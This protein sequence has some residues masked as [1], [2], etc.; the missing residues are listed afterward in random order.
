MS[1][2]RCSS[3]ARLAALLAALLL[4]GC[5]TLREPPPLELLALTAER[6][7]ARNSPVA[8]LLWSAEARGGVAPLS[9][10]FISAERNGEVRKQRGASSVWAWQP[11]RSG[12]YR[13]KVIVRDQAGNRAE[14]PWSEEIEI[15]RPLFVVLPLQNLSGRPA[16]LTEI[17]TALLAHLSAAGCDAVADQEMLA[18]MAGQRMRNVGGITGSLAGKLTEATGAEAVL[19]TSLELFEEQYPPRIALI[20][21]LVSLA[22]APEVLWMDSVGLA[23]DDSPGFLG[24]GIIEQPEALRDKALGMLMR[25]LAEVLAGMEKTRRV[26]GKFQPKTAYGTQDMGREGKARIAVTP[27]FNFSDRKYGG[28]I[29]A[30]HFLAALQQSGRFAVIEPGMVH[31]ELLRFRII[32][33][34]G[35]SIPQVEAIF[36]SFAADFV[37]SGKVFDYQDPKGNWGTPVV[38]FSAE[39]LDNQNHQVVWTSKSYNAGADGVYFFDWGRETTASAMAAGMTRAITGLLAP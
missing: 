13:L 12:V 39:M 5:A 38:D 20:S 31:E 15:S 19:I 22:Q 7:S 1:L 23:G 18:F 28:E 21:R 8:P 4:S 33:D 34:D 2:S 25:S 29:M 11:A 17:R 35:V 3:W 27:F 9:Y 10:E 32:M 26:P 24:L 30:L 36:S 14:S 16:P 6:T 37:L